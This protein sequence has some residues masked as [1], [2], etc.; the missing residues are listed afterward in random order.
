MENT[1]RKNS[2]RT[3]LVW[4]T[5]YGLEL[6]GGGHVC[7]QTGTV[8]G[9]TTAC[10]GVDPTIIIVLMAVLS[11]HMTYGMPSGR[12]T[13]CT[14][15]VD[16]PDADLCTDPVLESC[17][18]DP[19]RRAPPGPA[20]GMPRHTWLLGCS[21]PGISSLEMGLP[22]HKKTK[23][24][25]KNRREKVQTKKVTGRH[26]KAGHTPTA[27]THARMHALVRRQRRRVAGQSHDV[28]HVD[29]L[30]QGVRTR[31]RP[32]PRVARPRRL[33]AGAVI[34]RPHQP[35]GMSSRSGKGSLQVTPTRASRASNPAP[36]DTGGGSGR[37]H[38]RL[39]S[40][41]KT[42]VFET[43]HLHTPRQLRW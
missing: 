34:G 3:V 41:S 5:R 14:R 28:A 13:G 23:T 25:N 7:S 37:G 29:G 2:M 32:R 22:L 38:S 21:G 24:K 26:N 20:P 10:A 27:C 15:D 4:V 17:I 18:A 35:G 6:S 40:P 43:W 31:L 12:A 8:E 42:R 19:G 1:L 30:L 36:N 11:L 33:G 9:V 39:H 16:P